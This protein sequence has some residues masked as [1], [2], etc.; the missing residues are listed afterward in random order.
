[1]CHQHRQ[2]V[3]GQRVRGAVSLS[4][5]VV[6]ALA[7]LPQWV[8]LGSSR[9]RLPRQ[10]DAETPNDCPHSGEICNIVVRALSR[11][12]ATRRMLAVCESFM[13]KGHL[14]PPVA[15]EPVALENG[16]RHWLRVYKERPELAVPMGMGS[17]IVSGPVPWSLVLTRLE[18]R[19]RGERWQLHTSLVF[20]YLR[21]VSERRFSPILPGK[22]FEKMGVLL[23]AV[24]PREHKLH[25]VGGEVRI[26]AESIAVATR[27][28]RLHATMPQPA[29][30][31][32]KSPDREQGVLELELELT[33]SKQNVA[34]GRL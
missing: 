34:E 7:P 11:E 9:P 3:R 4:R 33:V 20:P 17:V 5:G 2:R 24:E 26:D 30:E 13:I 29:L 19:L 32:I 21:A 1:M 6:F 22:Y 31:Q 28:G 8:R 15:C 12:T 10:G 23:I 18:E 14:A 25:L 16:A 27:L